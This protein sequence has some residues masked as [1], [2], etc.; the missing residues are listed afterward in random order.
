MNKTSLFSLFLTVIVVVVA[1]E[2]LVNDYQ[3]A[4]TGGAASVVGDG[5]QTHDWAAEFDTLENGAEGANSYEATDPAPDGEVR[6]QTIN[7]DLGDFGEGGGAAT[8]SADVL[9]ANETEEKAEIT[10]AL[11]SLA[12]FQNVTLQRVPFNGILFERI[13]LRDFR[14]VPVVLQNVLQNNKNRIAGF[15]EFHGDSDLLAG[16]V[17][18]FIKEKAAASLNVGINETNGYGDNSFFINFGD[19][20]DAAFLVVK[21]RESVYAL[22]YEKGLHA[23]IESLISYLNT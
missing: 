4:G 9:S 18:L 5:K 21:I 2:F 14:S 12:G 22:T 11:L 17:Y 13:D 8:P 1:A 6:P 23:F 20:P 10:F 7:F 16:E 3:D 19:R 15:A